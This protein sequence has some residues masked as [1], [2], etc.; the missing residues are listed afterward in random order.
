MKVSD[1]QYAQVLW[2]LSTDKKE[3]E[4]PKIISRFF[5]FL[6]EKQ[7]GHRFGAILQ[8]LEG[9]LEENNKEFSLDIQSAHSLSPETKKELEKYFSDKYGAQKISWKE[10]VVPELLG[11]FVLRHKSLLLDA[12]LKY[13][14]QK[15][16]NKLNN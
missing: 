11:A 16:K 6:K 7:A 5:S 14:L 1:K 13:R 8:E 12:S 4:L 3:K 10:K 2:E 15:L 9:I